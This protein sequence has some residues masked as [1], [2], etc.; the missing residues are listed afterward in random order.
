MRA[1]VKAKLEARFLSDE[2]Q[3]RSEC[4]QKIRELNSV[5]LETYRIKA[6]KETTQNKKAIAKEFELAFENQRAQH[7]NRKRTIEEQAGVVGEVKNA[8]ER[9][10]ALRRQMKDLADD[11]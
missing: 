2:N 6:E 10:D 8:K 3:M 9:N 11:I 5:T 4:F 1:Q 7:N